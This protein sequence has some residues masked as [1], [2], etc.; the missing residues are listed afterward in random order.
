MLKY[1]KLWI[2]VGFSLVLLVVYLS[3][4]R[5]PPAPLTFDHAD[6]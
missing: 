2:T 1:R 6:S 5:N 3:L 4:T